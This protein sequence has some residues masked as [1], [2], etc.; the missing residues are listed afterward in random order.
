MM[1][2]DGS[3]F[4]KEKKGINV[5]NKRFK[6]I[7]V[8]CLALA[9]CLAFAGCG[10]KENSTGMQNP[11]TEVDEQGLIDATGIDMP[12]PEGATDVEYFVIEGSDMTIGEMRFT[13]DG[14]SAYLRSTPTDLTSFFPENT[15][16]ENPPDIDEVGLQG[17]ISGLNYEWERMA[18]IEVC[19]RPGYC[20]LK[21][22][23]GYVAWIDVAPGILYNLGMEKDAD[24]DI[25]VELAE[26]VFKPIQGD[27]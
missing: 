8:M 25:L 14:K 24:E 21:D 7:L 3:K 9:M 11:M 20:Q 6:T 10:D 2:N 27:A 19:G 22:D 17:D 4:L 18:G 26:K 23:I 5:M 13:L 1:Y 12:A 16:E 15:D